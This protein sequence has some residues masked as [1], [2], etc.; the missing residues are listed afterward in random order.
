MIKPIPYYKTIPF[1]KLAKRH[2]LMFN[3]NTNYVGYYIKKELV[4]IAGYDVLK[5]KCIIRSAYVL[6]ECRSRGIYAELV[7]YRINLLKEKGH[8][9]FELTCTHMSLPYHIKRGAKVIKE[10]K[11]YTKVRYEA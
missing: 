6:E 2:G 8:S 10:F 5:S 3:E 1:H 11:K 9:K 4:A 7:N